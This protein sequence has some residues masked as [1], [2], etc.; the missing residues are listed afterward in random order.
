M[1]IDRIIDYIDHKLMKET[2]GKV[3]LKKTSLLR[4]IAIIGLFLMPSWAIAQSV[5]IDNNSVHIQNGNQEVHIGLGKGDVKV[6]Q[7]SNSSSSESGIGFINASLSNQSFDD[8]DLVGVSF[9]NA[10]LKN[11]SFRNANLKSAD[12]T[13]AQ[14]IDCDFRGANVAGANFTNTTFGGSFIKGVD[15]STS[16]LTNADMSG[17][18]QTSFIPTSSNAISRGLNRPAEDG[19]PAFINLSITFDFDKSDISSEGF[20][21]IEELAKALQSPALSSA[22]LMVEGHT[23]SMGS[24]DYNFNLSNKRAQAIVTSLTRIYHISPERLQ[25]R[26]YGEMRPVAGNDTDFGRAQNR[27]VTILNLA[28]INWRR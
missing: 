28:S 11:I 14:F 3:M 15:F 18:D 17:A 13:N 16:N 25:S 5:N 10:T 8:K 7:D 27:R 26:G 12:F 6:Q 21:Q 2:K 22:T 1:A 23:D 20:A 4:S 19:K 24:D 9:I